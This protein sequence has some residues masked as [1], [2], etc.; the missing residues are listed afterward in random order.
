MTQ[1]EHII[2]I[3]K[4]GARKSVAICR[5]PRWFGNF[6]R[7][8]GPI[9]VGLNAH[10]VPKMISGTWKKH[11][12]WQNSPLQKGSSWGIYPPGRLENMVSRVGIPS[13]MAPPTQTAG[14]WI[15]SYVQSVYVFQLNRMS[16]ELRSSRQSHCQ[17]RIYPPYLGESNWHQIASY[18]ILNRLGDRQPESQVVF[19]SPCCHRIRLSRIASSF[20]IEMHRRAH[21]NRNPLMLFSN[22]ILYFELRP[23]MALEF[24]SWMAS[25]RT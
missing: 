22:W 4:I 2:S 17:N 24:Q 1:H 20:K 25:P 13:R 3:W 6:E 7:S 18:G 16:F 15:E 19:C 12:L 21:S 10:G 8:C 23:S 9:S 5:F 11:R 14:F